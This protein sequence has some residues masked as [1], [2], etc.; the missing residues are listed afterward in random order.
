MFRVLHIG[1]SLVLSGGIENY[2]MNLYKSIDRANIQFDFIVSDE[3]TGQHFFSTVESMG[4]VIYYASE[5]KRNLIISAIKKY[6][7]IKKYKQYGIVHIHTSCGIRIFD[8]LIARIVGIKSIIFHSHTNK[9][10]LPMKYKALQPLFN[11]IGTKLL[12]CSIEAGQYFFGK[13]VLNNPKFLVVPNAIDFEKYIYSET[14]RKQIRTELDIKDK[15]VFGFIGR[16]SKEKNLFFIIDIFKYILQFEPNSTLLLVGAGE[17]YEEVK[18]YSR[19]LGIS[20]YVIFTGERT[21]VYAIASALDILLLPSQYEGI[22][23]VLIEAQTSGLLCYASNAVSRSAQFTEYL[24]F[25][26]L[27]LSAEMW[28]NTIMKNGLSYSRKDMTKIVRDSV[29]NS[30]KSSEEMQRLYLNLMEKNSAL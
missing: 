29:Y 27:E 21:D 17:L 25:I 24:K 16:F 10:K 23:I 7:I 13:N 14:Q 18:A 19:E 4:G 1:T 3:L 15:I 30:I 20:E 11:C 8:G 26:S 6:R 2:V 5:K 9:M 22:P 12:A 28:A